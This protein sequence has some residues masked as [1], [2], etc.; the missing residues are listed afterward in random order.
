MAKN[1]NFEDIKDNFQYRKRLVSSIRTQDFER[2]IKNFSFPYCKKDLK[3]FLVEEG[4]LSEDSKDSYVSYLHNLLKED[5]CLL[6]EK[7]FLPIDD[8]EIL[9]SEIVVLL[10]CIFSVDKKHD[11]GKKTIELICNQLAPKAN[12]KDIRNA[13]SA[14]RKYGLFLEKRDDN[15]YDN[16]PNINSKIKGVL[17][18]LT[19]EE[20]FTYDYKELCDKLSFSMWT[21]DRLKPS[22]KGICYPIRLVGSLLSKDEKKRL[23]KTCIDKI[24][25]YYK[26]GDKLNCYTVSDLKKNKWVLRLQGGNVELVKGD[27][28]DDTEIVYDCDG[29]ELKAYVGSDI[30]VEHE[31][32]IANILEDDTNSFPYLTKLSEL[33]W[34]ICDNSDIPVKNANAKEIYKLLKKEKMEDLNRLKENVVEDLRTILSDKKINLSLMNTA[35][36]SSKGKHD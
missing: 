1:F 22:I 9:L 30:S 13:R 20:P 26:E 31:Y 21:Q 17:Q 10:P 29:E 28:N 36:N 3:L 12:N 34:D 15:L 35:K 8:D 18:S 6:T 19:A 16:I 33:I 5:K 4:G 25:I 2:F 32:S 14:L 24:R 7:E 11:L 27:G 23:M